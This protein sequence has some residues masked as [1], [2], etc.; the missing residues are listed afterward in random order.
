MHGAIIN[1]L[2]GHKDKATGRILE[3]G[4][5]DVN[6]SARTVYEITQGVDIREGKGVDVVLDAS[7][8]IEYYGEESFDTVVST[9]TL[10]HVKDWKGFVKNTWGVLKDGGW[11]IMTMA[12]VKK[13]RHD[14]PNDYQRFTKKEILEIWPNA[15]DFSELSDISIGWTVK[16]EGD[17]GDLDAVK[18]LPVR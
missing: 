13:G 15:Q 14:Y 4:S 3:V 7:S 17:L 9:E 11:L 6:G 16:K 2:K 10:E 5:F 8:L 1:Y 18:P 12:S